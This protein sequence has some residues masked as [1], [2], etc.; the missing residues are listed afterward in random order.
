MRERILNVIDT[1]GPRSRPW[2]ERYF[3]AKGT[4]VLDKLLADG[5]LEH[6][7]TKRGSVVRRPGK[8]RA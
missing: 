3:G 5:T 8:A 6:V 4:R 1:T 2:L 7:G